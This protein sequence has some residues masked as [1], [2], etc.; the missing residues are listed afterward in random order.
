MRAPSTEGKSVAERLREARL[1]A[2]V[3]QGQVAKLLGYHRP[4]ITEIEA[5]RRK[6]SAE[7]IQKFAETYGV[8]VNWLLTGKQ[9]AAAQDAKI[10][11]AA[12]EL[13]KMSEKDLDRLIATIRTLRGR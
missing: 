6:V 3:S 4:T 5:D 2:G 9:S 11:L 7:E 12:R 8:S 13:S 1:A 10:L